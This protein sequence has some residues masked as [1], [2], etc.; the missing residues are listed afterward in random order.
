MT[1]LSRGWGMQAAE[2]VATLNGH[3]GSVNCVL[4]VPKGGETVWCHLVGGGALPKK[5]WSGRHD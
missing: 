5:L 2:V 4:W 1:L 3:T